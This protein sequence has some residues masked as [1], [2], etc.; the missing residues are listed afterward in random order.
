MK[1]CGLVGCKLSKKIKHHLDRL[2]VTLSYCVVACGA[3]TITNRN[4]VYVSKG[5]AGWG[6][7]SITVGYGDPSEGVGQAYGACADG[8][9]WGYPYDVG[10]GTGWQVGYMNTRRIH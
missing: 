9:C 3:L 6:H 2:H 8:I 10:L 4:R 1:W 5:A 7:E